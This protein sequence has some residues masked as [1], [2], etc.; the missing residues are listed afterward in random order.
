MTR[1]EQQVWSPQQRCGCA[2]S[3][4]WWDC[5]ATPQGLSRQ[6]QQIDLGGTKSRG[7]VQPRSDTL[8]FIH[9]IGDVTL[10]GELTIDS[11]SL[12]GVEAGQTQVFVT[13][14]TIA[15]V[16]DSVNGMQI[17]PTFFWHL[18]YQ[19]GQLVGEVRLAG[20]A[21]G[22]G[23]VGVDD[24]DLILANW[25]TLVTAG[26]SNVGDWSGDGSIGQADLQVVL[27]H[28]GLSTP[29]PDTNIPEPGT[30]AM[31]TLLLFTQRRRRRSA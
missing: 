12:T 14:D 20:D 18:D 7:D 28:W 9:A 25:G 27:D 1:S 30:L 19:S 3:G 10:D 5:S 2:I 23:F 16:F 8:A 24:L 26:N 17:D 15:G 6:H 21:T 4:L 13:A 11:E 31:L 22:D 29:A